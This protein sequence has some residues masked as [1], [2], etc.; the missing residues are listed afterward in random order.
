MLVLPA[1]QLQ[2]RSRDIVLHLQKA[3]QI[4]VRMQTAS[5][6]NSAEP[7]GKLSLELTGQLH[8]KAYSSHNT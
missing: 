6:E 1:F 8:H 5:A 4:N 7:S 2:L 3:A